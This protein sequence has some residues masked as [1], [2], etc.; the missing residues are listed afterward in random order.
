MGLRGRVQARIRRVS[1]RSTASQRRGRRWAERG[2]SRRFVR[3][4]RGLHGNAPA[5]VRYRRA[6]PALSMQPSAAASR[7][8][9][10]SA[11]I[12]PGMP[13]SAGSYRGPGRCAPTTRHC[14][15]H[16]RSTSFT[17]RRSP[18]PPSGC[19]T[20][21]DREPTPEQQSNCATNGVPGG[22]YVQTDDDVSA[23]TREAIQAWNPKKD[24]RST[25][26]S[27]STQSVRRAGRQAWISSVRSWMA[28]SKAWMQ[29]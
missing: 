12:P 4:T 16:P 24:T 11:R 2:H 3:S 6:D 22:I 23:W 21:A 8:S 17:K 1:I 13:G 10:L 18:T 27:S 25:P 29:T 5:A 7:T 9:V 15:V 20:P 14:F 19:T 28:T 26:A